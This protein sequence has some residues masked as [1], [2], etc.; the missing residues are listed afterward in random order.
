MVTEEED[1]EIRKLHECKLAGHPKS[2]LGCLDLHKQKK[3][4]PVVHSTYYI[5][6]LLWEGI[7]F[8]WC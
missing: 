1:E 2:H 3:F 6:V 5:H 7:Q 4:L 8:F